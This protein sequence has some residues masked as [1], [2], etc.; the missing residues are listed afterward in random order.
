MPSASR[1]PVP[2][3]R[4]NAAEWWWQGPGL[5]KLSL[6]ILVRYSGT[7]SAGFDGVLMRGLMAN[8]LSMK[9]IDYAIATKLGSIVTVQSLGG[10]PGL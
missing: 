8:E 1:N 2:H 5:C 10:I 3:L 9:A 4:N 6:A 7:V